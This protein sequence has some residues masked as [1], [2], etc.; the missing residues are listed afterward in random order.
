MTKQEAIELQGNLEKLLSSVL[1]I[2]V[3]FS[4]A[5][6]G[7]LKVN[8]VDE[9]WY[10]TFYD[11]GEACYTNYKGDVKYF[12]EIIGKIRQFFFAN[13]NELKTLKWS[14]QNRVELKDGLQQKF[15]QEE[16]TILLCLPKEYTWIARDEN[17]EIYVF[18]SKPNKKCTFGEWRTFEGL[19]EKLPLY[20]HLFQSV[21][22][23]NDEPYNFREALRG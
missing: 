21:K 11:D 17:G 22:W 7:K 8:A 16:M 12:Q 23:A 19:Y 9:S 14:Y 10:F 6:S 20:K 4:L 18:E 2:E 5:L 13:S 15:T 3:E 1:S